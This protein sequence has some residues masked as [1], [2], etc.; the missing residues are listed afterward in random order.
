MSGDSVTF[1]WN[2]IY[3]Y[4]LNILNYI[5]KYRVQPTDIC[6]VS[7]NIRESPFAGAKKTVAAHSKE[8]V[9]LRAHLCFC[10]SGG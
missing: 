8:D 10:P 2:S 3:V 6:G 1:E 5:S 9:I 4:S 7:K